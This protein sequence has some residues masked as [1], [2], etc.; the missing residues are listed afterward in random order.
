MVSSICNIFWECNPPFSP[1]FL[2]QVSPLAPCNLGYKEDSN[3]GMLRVDMPLLLSISLTQLLPLLK[4]S[5]DNASDRIQKQTSG[6][7]SR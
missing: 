1:F 6:N 4:G 3:N 7:L 5:L 2:S